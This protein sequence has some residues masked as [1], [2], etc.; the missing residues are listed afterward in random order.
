M[1]KSQV[2]PSPVLTPPALTPDTKIEHGT[3]LWDDRPAKY[4][5]SVIKNVCIIIFV[6]SLCEETAN[7]AI[8]QSLKNFFQKLGWSNKGSNSMKLT[9]DSVSQFAC[10]VAGFIADEKIGKYNTLLSASLLDSFGFLVLLIAALPGVLSHVAV[11][12]ALFNIGL[13]LGVTFSQI[14]MH[15]LIISYGGDQFSP[16]TPAK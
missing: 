16:D 15:S 14:C 12:K 10:V 7:Y 5:V 13:F 2:S 4:K 3:E 8:N 9:Y 11:S 1:G 6:V